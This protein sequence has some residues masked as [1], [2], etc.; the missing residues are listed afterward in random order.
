MR[1]DGRDEIVW[2]RRALLDCGHRLKKHPRTVVNRCAVGCGVGAVSPV[3]GVGWCAV[4]YDSV[5][6]ATRGVAG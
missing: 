1:T 6:K 2:Q 4:W 3:V 5:D